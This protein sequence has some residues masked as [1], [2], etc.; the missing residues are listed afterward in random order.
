MA[1]HSV[2]AVGLPPTFRVQVARAMGSQ[3]DKIEWVSAVAAARELVHD[4]RTPLQLIVLSPEVG[5]L[6]ALDLAGLIRRKAPATAM[7]VVRDSAGNGFLPAAMRAGIRD[8]VDLS[9][10]GNE[11]PD[12]LALAIQ[13]SESLR[14]QQPGIPPGGADRRGRVVTV[15]SSKGGTGKTFLATN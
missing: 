13:W 12:A 1:E 11:L 7:V 15:F 3:P 14:A 8:V 10:G 2:L 5:D 4:G 9:R 6:E